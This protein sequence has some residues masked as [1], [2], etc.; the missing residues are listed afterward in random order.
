MDVTA[1]YGFGTIHWNYPINYTRTY[2]G[3]ASVTSG[4]V[5]E[6]NP[7]DRNSTNSHAANVG[8]DWELAPEQTISFRG[9]FQS[10]QAKH[11]SVYDISENE[12]ENGVTNT[13]TERSDERSKVNEIT[14]ALYYQGAF[15]NGWT[16]Y[17]AIGYDRMRDKLDNQYEDNTFTANGKYKDSKDYFRGELDLTRPLNE[18]LSL[19]FGYRGIWNRYQTHNQKDDLL[20]AKDQEGRHNGYAFFDWSITENLLLHIGS[21]VEAIHKDGIGQKHDWFEIL[22]QLTATW[23]PSDKVQLMAEYSTKMEYPSLFQVTGAT[24][25]IDRWLVQTGNS[26]LTPSRCHSVS[27]QG[28]FFESLV[29]GAEYGYTHNALTDWYASADNNTFL[30]TFA[31]ARGREFKAIAGYEWN[32]MEG[33]TWS[34]IVQW[35]WHDLKGQG[36]S[37]H[38]SY[39]S[40]QSNVEYWLKPVAM[41][42]KIEYMREMVKDPLLQGWQQYGQDLWQ[43]SLRKSFFNRSLSV[44]IN[45]VPPIHWGVRTNQKSCI[46]TDFFYQQLN[47][48]LKTYDNLLMLRIRWNFN[49]GGSKQRQVQEYE[50]DSEKKQEKGLL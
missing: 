35:Q 17:S 46:N 4:K 12:M 8:V 39:L 43:I 2:P 33:M 29:I 34:N 1:G 15:K 5:S 28:T 24:T 13:Y 30:K 42:A 3:T 20:L 25:S 19:N 49:K 10:D 27:L 50:F 6:K 7:N 37:N 26:Q 11:H 31:N 36:L 22:P 32:I 18:T 16:I 9:T 45:Y 44:S 40:W 38:T 41:L 23:Q 47:Q 21:G 14:A 48:N